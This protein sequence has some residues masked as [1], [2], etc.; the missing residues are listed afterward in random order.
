MI[1]DMMNINLDIEYQ[2]GMLFMNT[3][4]LKGF[5]PSTCYC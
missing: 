3:F 4:F 2:I 1:S 5:N